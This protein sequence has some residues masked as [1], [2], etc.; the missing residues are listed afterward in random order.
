MPPLLS[1]QDLTIRYPGP[2]SQRPAVSRLNLDVAA[3]ETLALVGESGCGKSTTALSLLRLLPAAAQVSGRILLE[4][5]DLATLDEAAMVG[6]RGSTVA[7]IFQE[8]MTSLNPVATVGAQLVE[9][10]RLHLPLSPAAARA[11]AVELLDQVRLPEPQ[12]RFHSYPHQLSGGQRQRA[13]IAMAIACSPRL[14]VADEPTTAL[15]V[16]VQAQ[17]L[18]LLDT[19]RRELSMAMLLITHDLGVVSQWADRVAVMHDG[20]KVEENTTQALFAAPLH[21]YTRGLLDASLSASPGA[22]YRV[23]RLPEIRVERQGDGA[24]SA[25]RLEWPAVGEHRHH[26][27]DDAAPLLRV[28]DL[29]VRHAAATQEVHAVRGVSFAIGAGETV[30]LVGE[31]GCGKSTLAKAILRLTHAESGSIRFDGIDLTALDR[32]GMRPLRGAMQLVFQDPYGSLN[33]RRT[34]AELLDSA[35]RIHGMD[36]RRERASRTAAI[37]DRVGLPSS[38]LQRYPHEFSGGQRQRIGIARALVLKPRLLICD[39]PVSALDVSVQAQVLNLLADLQ[40]EFGLSYLF[41]SH[42]LGVVRYIADRVLV[43]QQ[44]QLVE[45]GD[46]R[47]IWERPAHPY[48]QALLDAVPRPRFH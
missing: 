29:H 24:A 2:P 47:Q 25:F 43:M 18:E 32:D 45:A 33:P 35:L 13:M 12:R 31:S 27:A 11:R 1:L 21:P 26:P 10:L 19:L 6:L 44:G 5:R 3:G 15:D 8:P 40:A 46:H 17:I 38:A 4:G 36:D 16:T 39:E 14:L 22:H 48:T 41:I 7:M 28:E 34:V 9:A 20:I 37:I 30:G 23:A 42:D